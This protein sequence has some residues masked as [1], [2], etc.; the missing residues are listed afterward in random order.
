MR[1]YLSTRIDG[2]TDCSFGAASSF[3]PGDSR[4]GLSSG[5]GG[6]CVLTVY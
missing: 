3:T 4:M 5:G 2:M 1:G 6:L